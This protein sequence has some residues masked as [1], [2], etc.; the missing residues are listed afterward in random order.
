MNRYLDS[1]MDT[2]FAY[3]GGGVAIV[4]AMVLA[5]LILMPRD[6]RSRVG[7]PAFLLGLHVA[8]SQ[9][10]RF[11]KHTPF[12][13]PLE[14]IGLFTVLL[15]FARCAYLLVF[16]WFI[17]LRLKRP[18]S[19][20]VADIVQVIIYFAVIFAVLHE[21]GAELGSLLTTSALLTAIVGLSLQETL[22]NLF[23]GL[24][25]QAQRP[26]QIG[27]WIQVDGSDERSAGQV[28]EINWRATKLI[29]NDRVEIIYPNG[30]LAKSPLRNFTQP[31]P[32]S[33]RF[34][35][36]QA[37]Y[38]APPH[39]VEAA[40]LESVRGSDGVLPEPAPQVWVSQ[41]ADS[42]IEYSVLYFIDR[43]DRKGNIDSEVRR[44]IWYA[45]QRAGINIPF[46]V[47]DVRIQQQDPA[48]PAAK[49]N[50][51][52]RQRLIRSLD[53]LEGLGE[54]WI[55][56]LAQS[57][58]TRLYAAGEDIIRQH[59][60][61]SELFILE[62]GDADVLI[63]QEGAG[64]IQVA[65]LGPG[66]VFGE[67]SLVTGEPRSA[68]VRARSVCQVVSIGHAQFAPVLEQNPEMVRRISDVL[69][70]R[71][72]ELDQAQA[73]HVSD[74]CSEKSGEIF[75]RIRRFFSLR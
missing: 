57:S 66:A 51:L 64:S 61:G 71:Q 70:K 37:S 32:V 39:I 15:C 47:R 58:Q 18:V 45:F 8:L 5:L 20:I 4:A 52:S 27:D 1:L 42:G 17:R 19:R 29:T 11:A 62:S 56:D 22:G 60:A 23:A 35:R 26:F 43:F 24:A 3:G 34:V 73:S 67:M 2:S 38:D 46:P 40:L 30:L 55:H 21:M 28:T 63:Q 33:R 75:E 69:A 6:Q 68:T 72:A 41:F 25:I 9:A 13:R 7:F 14:I 16:E 54:P 31:S 49:Q 50:E 65:T 53:F 74:D 44:R 10:H 48:Q 59:D 36:V 12:T